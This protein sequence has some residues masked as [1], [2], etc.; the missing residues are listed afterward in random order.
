MYKFGTDAP[1]VFQIPFDNGLMGGELCLPKE[2]HGLAVIAHGT[3]GGKHSPRDRFVAR[4]LRD[5][6]F[7]TLL[8]DCP[9]KDETLESGEIAADQLHEE[10]E[11]MSRRVGAV[12]EWLRD[13]PISGMLA[14]GY[15]GS[16]LGGAAALL[17]AARRPDLVRAVVT[18][19]YLPAVATDHLIRVTTP[20]L[21]VVGAR[22]LQALQAH[23][24]TLDRLGSHEKRIEVVPGAGHLFAEPGALSASALHA[25]NWFA[26]HLS[27]IEGALVTEPLSTLSSPVTRGKDL[28]GSGR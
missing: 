14:V 26:R 9:A 15:L 17:S 21:M 4:L 12:A 20:T 11:E 7:G 19:G 2:A 27:G 13:H 5:R 8:I 18:R 1:Q 6:G 28:V 22:D 16:G 10:L 24:E 25:A 23:R 3:G